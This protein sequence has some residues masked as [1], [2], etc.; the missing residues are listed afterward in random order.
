MSLCPSSGPLAKAIDRTLRKREQDKREA[1]AN[2]LRD[3]AQRLARPE[4]PVQSLAYVSVI[5]IPESYFRPVAPVVEMNKITVRKIQDAACRQFNIGR[6]D[7]VSARHAARFVV[8]RHAAMF[9]ARE[10]TDQST[11]QIGK[12]FERDHTGILHGVN[13]TIKRLEAGERYGDMLLSEH[14]EAIRMALK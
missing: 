13:Q 14:I 2:G 8:A 4:R 11:P 10:L 12:A 6:L 3:L 7:L 5:A 9:L 1:E